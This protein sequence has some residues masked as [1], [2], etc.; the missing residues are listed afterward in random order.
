MQE[1][2]N[3]NQNE[4]RLPAQSKYIKGDEVNEE[5]LKIAKQTNEIIKQQYY[6]VEGCNNYINIG[7]ELGKC[8]DNTKYIDKSETL[9]IPSKIKKN[10]KLCKIEV[11]H[12][13]TFESAFRIIKNYNIKNTVA[14]NFASA[15]KPGGGWL[16]GKDAQEES[17]TRQSCLFYSLDKDSVKKFYIDHI[18]LLKKKSFPNKHY[19]TNAMIYSYKVPVIR[20]PKN[21]KLISDFQRVSVITSAAPN[22]NNLI[23]DFNKLFKKEKEERERERRE[24]KERERKERLDKV[25]KSKAVKH[26]KK[27]YIPKISQIDDTEE[28]NQD[29]SNEPINKNESNGNSSNEV[30][31]NNDNESDSNNNNE[32]NTDNNNIIN[33]GNNNENNTNNNNENNVNNNNES[34]ADNNNENNANNNNESNADNNDESKSGEEDVN[35]VNNDDD[36]KSSSNNEDF[37]DE[38]DIDEI[39]NKDADNSEES[40]IPKQNKSRLDQAIN[41]SYTIFEER[42][43]RILILAIVEK[44][45]AIILGAFGCGV[46]KNDPVKVSEIFRKLL[47][48]EKYGYY[49][50]YVVFAIPGSDDS[51]NFRSFYST[52][53]SFLS[54]KTLE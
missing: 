19:Y 48:D 9:E 50:D 20:D 29:D 44:Q 43:K 45:R 53:E 2:H 16:N 37:D 4:K 15:T 31:T 3:F 51:K 27:S 41:E 33:T 54:K 21:E 47:I 34:N 8:F 6:S 28:H 46:F 7:K 24:K 36:D 40:R 35:S 18:K 10:K 39:N 22:L 42:I 30:S 13:S 52:F 12:E 1:R 38:N 17:I 11:S 5:K 23:I 25:K 14:L 26:N 49:F 32:S